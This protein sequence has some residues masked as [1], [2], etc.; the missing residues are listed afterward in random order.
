MDYRTFMRLSDRLLS[1]E[2]ALK[3]TELRIMLAVM[4]YANT[5]NGETCWATLEAVGERAGIPNR[6]TVSRTVTALVEKG[7]L[8]K[9]RRYNQPSLLRVVVPSELRETYNSLGVNCRKP[10]TR[11]AENLQP[12]LVNELS[13]KDIDI[14]NAISVSAKIDEDQSPKPTPA[15]PARKRRRPDREAT[16]LEDLP[17]LTFEQAKAKGVK[18]YRRIAE[19]YNALCPDLVRVRRLTGER[20]AAIDKRMANGLPDEDG[21]KSFFKYCQSR[22]LLT[23]RVYND[24]GRPPWRANLDWILKER[25]YTKLLE[26]QYR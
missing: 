23:G 10:A 12:N 7:L 1:T 21:W 13:Y 3:P 24:N 4:L 15:K 6:F 19:L 9:L 16:D 5:E 8:T 17:Q 26:K 14:A 18:P 25:N 22:E 11:I 2:P 20:K